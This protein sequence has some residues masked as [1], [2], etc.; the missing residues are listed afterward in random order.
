MT[1]SPDTLRT[2]GP[3]QR[4]SL[5]PARQQFRVDVNV[6]VTEFEWVPASSA[7]TVDLARA[8]ALFG[9][10]Q[11]EARIVNVH[12]GLVCFWSPPRRWLP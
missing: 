9:A 2:R 12:S 4:V 8:W 6:G 11:Y 5:D 7:S 3:D 10:M 1:P